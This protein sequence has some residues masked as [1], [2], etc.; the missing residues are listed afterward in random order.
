MDFLKKDKQQFY[1]EQRNYLHQQEWD[2]LS[3]L[4]RNFGVA[5]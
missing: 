4:D 5:K 3:A 1:E 2:F